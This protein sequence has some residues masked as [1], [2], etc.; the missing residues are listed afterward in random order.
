MPTAFRCANKEYHSLFEK[1]SVKTRSIRTRLDPNADGT[2][3]ACKR[4]SHLLARAPDSV[5]DR[6]LQMDDTEVRSTVALGQIRNEVQYVSQF[7]GHP[8]FMASLSEDPLGRVPWH[9]MANQA[10]PPPPCASAKPA[11][12]TRDQALLRHAAAP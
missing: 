7:C 8:D 11:G 4:R 12:T 2:A 10:R 9:F 1:I 5:S 3:A 6:K